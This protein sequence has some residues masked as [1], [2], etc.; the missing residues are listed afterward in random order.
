MA[1][2]GASAANSLLIFVLFI[3]GLVAGLGK[4]FHDDDSENQLA[5]ALYCTL[6][7]IL[8]WCDMVKIDDGIGGWGWWEVGMEMAEGGGVIKHGAGN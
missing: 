4:L 1:E 2:P 7:K 5:I 6:G 3:I 8:K